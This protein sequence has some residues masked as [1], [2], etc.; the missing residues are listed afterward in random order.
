MAR[1][2]AHH[3]ATI[4]RHFIA[5][6]LQT[7]N[8]VGMLDFAKGHLDAVQVVLELGQ[9]FLYV[10]REL[11]TRHGGRQ[12]I[13][14][15]DEYDAQDL[16]RS[17]LAIFFEDVRPEDVVPTKA[18]ASSRVDF[19]LPDFELAVE[20]KFARDSMSAKSLG[21]EL[22][23]DRERYAA[24]TKVRHLIC[25]VFDHEGRLRNP[26]GLEGDLSRETSAEGFA[27]T[28]RIYDR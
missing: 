5:G 18:G 23:V 11:K 22:I 8:S 4:L 20:L 19:V 6:D 9:R 1:V 2:R 15:S 24:N 26:R 17:M 21:E 3:L 13:L 27:V 10:E 12:T 14:I 16:M 28:V 7:A 25:L